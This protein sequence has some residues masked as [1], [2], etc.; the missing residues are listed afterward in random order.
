[1][2]Q[3]Y[4]CKKEMDSKKEHKCLPL[5]LY[6]I[7]ENEEEFDGK[8]Y[9]LT[10]AEAAEKTADQEE[11]NFD[12]AFVSNGEINIDIKNPTTNKIKK[13]IVTAWQHIE[14]SAKEIKPEKGK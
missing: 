7:G 11:S 1:M 5:W 9:A 13:F 2:K 12:F 6:R 10:E 14:Y 8:I 4:I 3:C